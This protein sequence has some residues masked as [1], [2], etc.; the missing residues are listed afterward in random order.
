MD[1][2]CICHFC[3]KGHRNNWVVL[4]GIVGTWVW[5]HCMHYLQTRRKSVHWAVIGD[6]FLNGAGYFKSVRAY[7]SQR[8]TNVKYDEGHVE[9]AP[10]IVLLQ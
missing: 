10:S 6:C 4:A 8:Y 2:L 5:T 7:T 3:Q 1:S 9:T